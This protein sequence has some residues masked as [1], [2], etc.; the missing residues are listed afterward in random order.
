[1][2]DAAEFAARRRARGG[3]AQTSS[4]V[5]RCEALEMIA[6]LSIEL[7]LLADVAQQRAHAFQNH[8]H[9]SKHLHHLN[10]VNPWNPWN[11][12]NL[13]NREPPTC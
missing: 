8:S 6:D 7:R 5:I 1:M 3:L 2:I 10:L 13:V 4:N 11:L 12:S 9:P